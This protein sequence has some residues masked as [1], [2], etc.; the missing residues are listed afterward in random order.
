[1]IIH[2]HGNLKS[3]GLLNATMKS[4]VVKT[5]WCRKI[6]RERYVNHFTKIKTYELNLKTSRQN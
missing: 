6:E 1:M 5:D 4:N 3:N 2:Y